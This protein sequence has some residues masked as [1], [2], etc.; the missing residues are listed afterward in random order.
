RPRAT[1]V[2]CRTRPFSPLEAESLIR[3]FAA[4]GKLHDDASATLG[5]IAAAAF[6][7]RLAGAHLH[8]ELAA[9]NDI[10]AFGEH[11]LVA[12]HHQDLAAH[13]EYAPVAGGHLLARADIDLAI[14]L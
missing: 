2:P 12:G 14:R 13:V 9:D 10:V 6:E 1:S 11:H 4:R 5:R 7:A 8:G 3:L